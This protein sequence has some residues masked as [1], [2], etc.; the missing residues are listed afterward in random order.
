L[1]RLGAEVTPISPLRDSRIPENTDLL[2]L[3]GGYPEEFRGELIGNEN[4]MRSVRDFAKRGCVYAECGGMI[5]LCGDFA[6]V[7]DARAVTTER[8]GRFGYVEGRALGDNLIMSRG[9]TVRAHEFH[10]SRLEGAAPGAFSVRKFSRPEEEW[11]DGYSL[12]DGRLLA[13]HLYMN[14]YSRPESARIMLL[15][16]AGLQ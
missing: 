13:T 11:T 12:N 4:F 6:G 9:E 10:Y 15:H 3:P 16:A 1:E 5:Y 8:L 2:I 14:F 7:I